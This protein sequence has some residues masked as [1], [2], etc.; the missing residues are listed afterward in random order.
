MVFGKPRQKGGR[1][2]SRPAAK[3]VFALR[4]GKKFSVRAGRE[5]KAPV[6]FFTG[7]GPIRLILLLL[8]VDIS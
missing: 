8:L 7:P 1:L 3:G 5:K 2:E 4:A 6:R